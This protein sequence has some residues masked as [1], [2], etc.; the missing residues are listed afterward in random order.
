MGRIKVCA[1]VGPDRGRTA[2]VYIDT[3]SCFENILYEASNENL[4]DSFQISVSER[5]T[6]ALALSP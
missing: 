4:A 3:P 2:N 5:R 6:C 1:G